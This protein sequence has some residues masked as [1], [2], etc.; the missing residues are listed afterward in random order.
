MAKAGQLPEL[1]YNNRNPRQDRAALVGGLYFVCHS[2]GGTQSYR[3]LKQAT[4]V[5][6]CGWNSD[7]L[8]ADKDQETV[9]H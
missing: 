9:Q 4:L 1:T 5:C 8:G 6:E 3:L 2:P 7:L